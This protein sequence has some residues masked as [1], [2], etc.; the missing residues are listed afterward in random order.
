MPKRH[1]HKDQA[2]DPQSDES[3][4]DTQVGSDGNVTAPAAGQATAAE[5]LDPAFYDESGN[6]TGS[7]AHQAEVIAAQK[8]A[9]TEQNAH[10]ARRGAPRDPDGVQRTAG[11]DES[12][13]PVGDPASVPGRQYQEGFPE[14]DQA[15]WR[16]QDDAN[17]DVA[18]DDEADG[19]FTG[20][21]GP[22][23]ETYGPG[24]TGL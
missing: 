12:A 24:G 9:M 16:R 20:D 17:Q 22:E 15:A 5:N 3:T 13:S 1:Q 19:E 10:A 4:E 18:D 8:Q 11:I 23:V 21:D 14:E 2:P 6:L 7:G